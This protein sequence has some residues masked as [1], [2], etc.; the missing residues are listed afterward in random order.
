MNI[1]KKIAIGLGGM[2]CLSVALSI[3]LGGSLE[4]EA[5]RQPLGEEALP[6][7]VATASH[8]L[9]V[10]ILGDSYSTFEGWIPEGY[11]AWYKPV[12]KEGRPTDV[13][14]VDQTWWKLF[15]DR[16]GYELERNNSYSGSTVCNT[17]YDGRDYSDQAFISRIGMLGDPDLILVFGGTNDAWAGSP[18]GD[19]VWSAW[20]PGQLYS[21][22]PAAAY[23]VSGLKDAYPDARIVVLINDEIS[24]DVKTSTAEICTHYG[25]P[26]L[27]LEGIEKMSGHPDRKG[28]EQIVEQL[29]EFL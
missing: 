3:C 8:P 14:E 6:D 9:K 5:A 20:E 24:D 16:N 23:M 10:S 21:Y 7:S 12:P 4:G 22:R 29:E 25:I 15:I 1:K 13:T 27:Q 2:L 18:I 11:L 19:Y 17:G 28:M 26:Y